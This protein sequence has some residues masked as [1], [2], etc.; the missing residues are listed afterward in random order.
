MRGERVD[1]GDGDVLSRVAGGSPEAFEA[2]Y[3]RYGRL[4]Y[5]IALRVLS[6]EGAA[7]EVVQD[8]FLA[9][10]RKTLMYRA[11][12]GSVRSWVATVV[13]NAAIDRLRRDQR[14]DR[15][16]LDVEVSASRASLS[17]TWSEV[18][19]ELSRHEIRTAMH[20]LPVEQRQTLELAYWCGLS[21]REISEA[22]DVPV[23]T[24][25]GRARL[26]LHKLRDALEGREESW[27]LR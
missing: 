3:D 4:A 6:D 11:E 15:Y 8:A 16:E 10:W 22:M 13:R 7:E 26:G 19:E 1:S 24:V 23:G 27:Q 12:R 25:K 14:R 18:A 20:T 2:L 5:A 9:V 17:D 21:Q